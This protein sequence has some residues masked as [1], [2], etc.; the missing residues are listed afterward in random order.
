[1]PHIATFDGGSVDLPFSII[2]EDGATHSYSFLSLVNDPSPGIRYMTSEPA[3]TINGSKDVDVVASYTT[4]YFL[5][6]HTSGLGANSTTIT[7]GTTILGAASASAPLGVWLDGG[8]LTLSASANL[9]GSDGAQYF[10]QGFT[11]ASPANLTAP[12]TTTVAYETMAEVVA[13]ALASGGITGPGASGLGN[14]FTQQFAAVQA[15]LGGH[16]YVQALGDLQSFISHAQAQSGKQ[17]TTSMAQTFQLDAL[18]VYHNALCLA[19][20]AGQ[21]TP[22]TAAADYTFYSTLVARLGGTVLPPC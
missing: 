21:I 10:F 11:P 12:F 16:H 18:L 9:N 20:A 13:G 14:T 4:Q 15:D 5:T 7:N 2:I 6:V 3:A 17:V 8:P 1:V 22:A 19:G